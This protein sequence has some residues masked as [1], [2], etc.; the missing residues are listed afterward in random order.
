MNR[1]LI[2][3]SLVL[4]AAVACM[5]KE[6]SAPAPAP[7]ITTTQTTSSA[8]PATPSP[9]VALPAG[10]PIPANGLA[11]WLA[12]DDAKPSA[13]GKLASWSNIAVAGV[14]A[15]AGKPELQPTVVANGFNGHA[16]V[17]FDGEKNLLVT[18]V[19]ISPAKMPEATVFAV[20][21]SRTA[22][23]STL[24]KLYGDDNAGYDRAVGLDYRGGDKNFT[25]FT[26]NGVQ[27]YF[28]LKANVPY[29]TADQFGKSD[30]SGWVN[31]KPA[32]QKV[33]AAWGEALPNLYIAGTG[34]VFQEPWKGD[35][36]EIIVYARV[37]TD[38]ERMQ[39]EDYLGKKY[40]V[41]I[42]R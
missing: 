37:L 32:L 4:L 36:A 9:A 11:L 1:K 23:S 15:T 17:R 13:G 27:G 41:A 33:A 5:K 8:A 21:S 18:N 20:F 30:F 24:R 10:T 35:L 26:G 12:A 39:V 3:L 6:E 14:T 22:E 19:D 28:V 38:P 42:T 2:V 34:T 16:V 31:G 29:V 25:I 40:G 7:A